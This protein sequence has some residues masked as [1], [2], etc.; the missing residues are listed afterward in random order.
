MLERYKSYEGKGGKYVRVRK[1]KN[2]KEVGCNFKYGGQYGLT[3][4]TFERRLKEL[5]MCEERAF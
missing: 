3:E 5:W 4:M 2:T 1:I